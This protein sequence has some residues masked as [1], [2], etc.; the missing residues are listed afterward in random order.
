ML[1]SSQPAPI[2][3]VKE[4]LVVAND[5]TMKSVEVHQGKLIFRPKHNRERDAKGLKRRLANRLYLSELVDVSQ[6]YNRFTFNV[7]QDRLNQLIDLRGWPEV[8]RNTLYLGIS[9]YSDEEGY[10]V[11]LELNCEEYDDL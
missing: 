1:V 6:I 9:F 4:F 3:F 10:L 11:E 5:L 2:G 7:N 8:S